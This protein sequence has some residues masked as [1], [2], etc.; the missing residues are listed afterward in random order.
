[1]SLGIYTYIHIKKGEQWGDGKFCKHGGN[2]QFNLALGQCC[3][4]AA[5]P[6][7]SPFHLF[8]NLLEGLV[9]G[10]GTR[11][12]ESLKPPNSYKLDKKGSQ[13]NYRSSL[14]YD[15]VASR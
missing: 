6:Q 7:S 11:L 8:S 3:K 13:V 1:M 4:E 14:I 9:W 12:P 5:C 10:K 2:T 15:E